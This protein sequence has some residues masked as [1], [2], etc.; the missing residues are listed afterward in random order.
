MRTAAWEAMSSF[1]L[2]ACLLSAPVSL[3]HGQISPS[4]YGECRYALDGRPVRVVGHAPRGTTPLDLNGDTLA[5][6]A[7]LDSNG[8]KLIILLSTPQLANGECRNGVTLPAPVAFKDINLSDLLATRAEDLG[9]IDLQN[10][11]VVDLAVGQKGRSAATN[12]GAAT[13]RTGFTKGTRASALVV[14]DFDLD[15][16]PAGSQDIATAGPSGV[17]ISYGTGQG[18]DDP[19]SLS[20]FPTMPVD[21]LAV[22]DLNR[23]VKPDIVVLSQHPAPG[24]G[25]ISVLLNQGNR[26]FLHIPLP[27]GAVEFE[28]PV[29]LAIG[30]FDDDGAPDLVVVDGPGVPLSIPPL[31][32]SATPSATV[33]VTATTTRTPTQTG[34]LEPTVTRTVTPTG[35]LEPTFTE[36]G[37]PPPTSTVMSTPTLTRT[38][39]APG[40]VEFFIS[41]VTPR[42]NQ[43]SFRH[44]D[45][46]AAGRGPVA[47]Q[48]DYMNND[49]V[50]DA[51]VV[52]VNDDRV[53][54]YKGRGNGRFDAEDPCEE[55]SCTSTGGAIGGCCVGIGPRDL[56]ITRLDG[57]PRP[58]LIVV[59]A[60]D[61]S[62]SVLLSTVPPATNTN[63]PTAT[64]TITNTPG[65]TNSPTITRTFSPIPPATPP[66][67]KTCPPSG[68]CVQGE[69]C[70]IAAPQGS[71][72]M[73]W[74]WIGAAVLW[75]LRKK[76]G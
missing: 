65:P 59:N 18:F 43:V 71:M 13:F 63:T 57:E 17:E 14:A 27:L 12:D 3:A 40:V 33:T 42:S 10:N 47:V 2:S 45:T 66:P 28:N 74:P 49:D 39:I 30:D 6:A 20:N 56:L 26:S 53:M 76:R 24:I 64:P 15:V 7:I 58:D 32:P 31:T 22:A 46:Q 72:A 73:V 4:L 51:V 21:R 35:S 11:D 75:M 55:D 41:E 9:T 48:V 52:S 1:W 37:T 69:S 60:D 36:T 16:S 8:T 70:A 62:I 61:Q 29:A 19:A 23:D 25:K 34:T 5:D 68:I 67:T 44:S 54:F 38:P 50:L